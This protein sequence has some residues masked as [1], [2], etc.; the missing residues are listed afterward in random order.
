MI[1]LPVLF[2]IF[3]M[4]GLASHGLAHGGRAATALPVVSAGDGQS[5]PRH[6]HGTTAP[7]NLHGTTAPHK[8]RGSEPAPD[9][10]HDLDGGVCLA[11][12]S[13]L[14][15]VLA[16]AL[17]AGLHARPTLLLRSGIVRLLPRGRPARP[18][19]LHRL[20]IMRC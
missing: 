17:R 16:Y 18:P 10:D 1:L 19:C 4:H 3:A 12:L 8:E 13:L 20:S 6:V 9:Q 15:G 14:A 2:A 5:G 7:H 11:L